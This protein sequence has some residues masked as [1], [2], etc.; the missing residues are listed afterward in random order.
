MSFSLLAPKEQTQWADVRTPLATSQ[1]Q[2]IEPRPTSKENFWSHGIALASQ[3]CITRPQLSTTV[4]LHKEGRDRGGEVTWAYSHWWSLRKRALK[5]CL[6]AL[7]DDGLLQFYER[8]KL[9]PVK[10]GS[11]WIFMGPKQE[12]GGLAHCQSGAVILIG[13]CF[14]ADRFSGGSSESSTWERRLVF[15]LSTVIVYF[16]PPPPEIASR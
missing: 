14:K 16:D 12:E 13:L 1:M 3:K 6:F 9:N 7:W 15:Q 8:L 2:T 4:S 11:A 5:F 10:A